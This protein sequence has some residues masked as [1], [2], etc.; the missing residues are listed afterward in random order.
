[1]TSISPVL[2]S[3]RTPD[4]PGDSTAPFRRTRLIRVGYA[5]V[6]LS[7]F[8]A[9]LISTFPYSSTLSKVLAPMGLEVSSTS[10]SVSFPFGARLSGV[11]LSSTKPTSAGLIMESPA[12]TIAPAFLSMLT[13]HPGVRIK[14]ALYDGIV[15][16]M[17]RPS[18]G[19][20]AIS[21]NLDSVDIARQSLFPLPD[22]DPSGI[23]SGNGNLWLD[24]GNLAQTGGGQLSGSHLVLRSPF[25]GVPI[26]LG[27]GQSKFEL[28]EGLLTIEQ[29]ATSGGDLVLN[30]TGT[31]QLAPTP[32]QSELA[33]EFTLSLSPAAASKL[34]GLFLLLPHPPG[35]Q[36]YH[37]TGTLAAPRIN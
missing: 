26:V 33:I 36:P 11:R 9:Y 30:A 13:F 34:S 21:Y 22:L 23:L 15:N 12:V 35:P 24:Q 29:C 4:V 18:G 2:R 3:P 25:L 14:A 8:A 16:V 28:N 20:T 32:E 31:V 10:Q 37:L 1:M 17:L 5:L 7:L 19:G 6:G 27:E